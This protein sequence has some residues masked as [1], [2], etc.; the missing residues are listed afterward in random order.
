M[1]KHDHEPMTDKL[2][3]RHALQQVAVAAT[4][5]AA[6][7]LTSS[8]AGFSLVRS[9]GTVQHPAKHKVV[10][11]IGA[12]SLNYRD[13]LVRQNAG[14]D[15][16]SGLIPLS[17]G[18]GTVE[19]IGPDVTRW[20]VGD[21]VS[22]TF[23]ADWQTGPFRQAYLASARGGG[24]VDGVLSHLVE[25]DEQAL[26]RVPAHL[27]LAEAATLPCAGVTAWQALFVRGRLQEGETVLVQGTGG[28]ALLALQLAVAAGARAIII[29]SSDAKLERAE[30]LG[31]WRTINYRHRPDW[32][33]AVLDLTNGEGANHVLELGGPETFERSIA[34]VAHG[35]TIAQ[36]GVLT[37]FGPAPNLNSLQFKN[38]TIHGICVGSGQHHAELNT[39]LERHDVHPIIDHRFAF[40]DAPAAYDALKAARHFGK[41]VINVTADA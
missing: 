38:A 39:F 41:L 12:A 4:A 25:I 8:G 9:T 31:A 24:V 35:G 13:L 33:R 7:R 40:D 17:D 37:G 10:V 14:S 28:V 27:S 36:I 16:K 21:R 6:Y 5:A 1:N 26:V 22:P 11:R 29:S 23:F 3:R 2:S 32:D 30:A 20:R 19:A 34:A 18:A 15:T